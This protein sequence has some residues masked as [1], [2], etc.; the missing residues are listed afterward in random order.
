M[1]CRRFCSRVFKFTRRSKLGDRAMQ[2]DILANN[3]TN[4]VYSMTI[5][6]LDFIVRWKNLALI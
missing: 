4:A 1:L 3:G 5:R 6:M 2:P